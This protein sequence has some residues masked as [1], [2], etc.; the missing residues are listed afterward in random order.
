MTILGLISFVPPRWFYTLSLPVVWGLTSLVNFD[1][2]GDEYGG[3]FFG[4]VAGIWILWLVVPFYP[5]GC[6][7]FAYM[8]PVV[9]AGSLTMALLGWMMGKLRCP[10][11][12]QMVGW[13]GLATGLVFY[14]LGQF[15]SYDLAMS[16]N[17]SLWAYVLPAL[18]QS[19][20]L[21]TVAMISVFAA[22]RRQALA[23]AATIRE[24][25]SFRWAARNTAMKSAARS[26]QIERRIGAVEKLDRGPHQRRGADV[27]QIVDK[28]LAGGKM[29][30][31][32]FAGHMAHLFNAAVTIVGPHSPGVSTVQK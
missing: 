19:L 4:S 3:F 5:D 32:G 20:L 22:W 6:S 17:G 9:A 26:R 27:F 29:V 12:P 8:P 10:V 24:H 21:V 11:V 2:P 14:Y 30:V 23:R 31:L 7:P 25:V 16:K 15:S 13:L 28:A 18:N 1:Y